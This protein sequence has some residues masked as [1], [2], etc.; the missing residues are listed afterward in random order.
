MKLRR[1][2]W[3]GLLKALTLIIVVAAFLTFGDRFFRSE[4]DSPGWKAAG[5]DYSATAPAKSL[6]LPQP[7]DNPEV[8]ATTPPHDM[9]AVLVEDRWR[10]VS[11]RTDDPS[12]P[13]A[14]T[15]DTFEKIIHGQKITVILAMSHDLGANGLFTIWLIES[16]KFQCFPRDGFN[17][18][19]SLD[20]LR[21]AP[22]GDYLTV[23]ANGPEASWEAGR[24]LKQR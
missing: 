16:G 14:T 2:H 7:P 4:P 15:W 24:C 20:L 23:G 12:I 9:A 21:L 5:P 8:T 19:S 6:G 17:L 10:K 22:E 13:N 11:S 1:I 18:S 3:G